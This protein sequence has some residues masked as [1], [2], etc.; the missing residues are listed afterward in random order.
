VLGGQHSGN[1]T[2]IVLDAPDCTVT[3]CRCRGN[4]GYGIRETAT[5]R[6]NGNVIVGNQVT[7][8]GVGGI[9]RGTGEDTVVA[10][11]VGRVDTPE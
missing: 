6:A 9:R 7:G 1:R 8:N 4:E 3:G 5:G 10:N 2:G 11:N